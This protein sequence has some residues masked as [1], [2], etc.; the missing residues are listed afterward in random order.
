MRS[1]LILFIWVRGF[2]RRLVTDSVCVLSARRPIGSSVAEAARFS[3]YLIYPRHRG[4]TG[5][6]DT[7]DIYHI[8]LKYIQL[9]TGMKKTEIWRP[10][11]VS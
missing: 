2:G 7:R 5:M 8:K 6:D 4:D 3:I 10:L 1:Y 11:T 9:S